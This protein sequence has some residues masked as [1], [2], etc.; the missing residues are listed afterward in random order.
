MATVENLVGS[1]SVSLVLDKEVL[2]CDRPFK[3]YSFCYG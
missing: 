2:Y 1:F 3:M